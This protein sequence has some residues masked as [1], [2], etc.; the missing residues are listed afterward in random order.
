MKTH[1]QFV[2][3]RRLLRFL[4]LLCVFS[5]LFTPLNAVKPARAACT[6]GDIICDM[7]QA[8]QQLADQYVTP[9]KAW[10]QLQSYKALYGIEYNIAHV[11]AAF[12]WTISRVLTTASV[13]IGILNQWIAINFFQP[14]IQMT[15]ATM[16]PIVGVFLFAALCVLGISYLLAAFIRLNV[17]SLRSVIVWWI[18][19]GFFFSLGPSFYLSMRNLNQSLSSVFQASAVNVLNGQNPFQ[20]L[21][22]G[23]S[24]ANNPVYA[25]TALCSN[26]NAFLNSTSGT[27]NGLDIS[28]A[29]QKADGYDVIGGGAK[30][31]GGGDTQ[32]L[33]RRWFDDNGFFDA[34]KAPGSWPPMVTCPPDPATCD[35]D[36]LVQIEAGKMQNSVN[37]TFAGIMR[38]WQSV[39]LGWFAVVEQL[40]GLCLICAQGLT[41]VSFACAMVFAFFKRTEPIAWAIV[42]Q[43]LSLIVQS[44][45]IALVQGMTLALYLAAAK[46]GSPLV[47]MAVSLAAL[48]FMVIL[49]ISGLKAVW[50]SFNKL[51]EAFGQASGGVF[52]SPGQAGG[53]IAGT[54]LNLGSA[55]AT[56]GLSLAAGAATAVGS[57]AG[58]VQALGSGATWAQA[59]GVTFGGSKAL[60]GAAYH[61]ARLPG[62]RNTGIGEAAGQYIEGASTRQV[63]DSLLG[64]APVVGGALKRLG[65]ASMGAA[66]LTDHNPD[67]VEAHLDEQGQA[68]W[69]QPMLQRS[70][71]NAVGRLLSGPT[72]QPGTTSAPNGAPLRESDGTPVNREG[73]R[74][75]ADSPQS[76]GGRGVSFTPLAL[77]ND[78][79]LDETLDQDFK[80]DLSADRSERNGA[81]NSAEP[82]NRAG[83]RLDE[84]GGALKAGADALTRA[85][86]A[87]ST[88]KSMEQVEGRLNVSGA[89]NVAPVMARVVESLHQQNRATGQE[90]ANTERVSAAMAGVM[91]ISPVE[92]N[93]QVVPPIEGRVS[94][95][96]MFADQALRMGLSGDEAQQVVREVK[97]SPDGRLQPATRDRLAH[98]QHEERGEA[99][100]DSVQSVQMLEHSARLLPNTISAYGTRA[101]PTEQGHAPVILT[102]AASSG[103]VIFIPVP[104]PSTPPVILTSVPAS[105]PAPVI[106]TPVQQS[107]TSTDTS[108]ALSGVESTSQSSQSDAPG[109]DTED[110]P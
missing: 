80:R 53:M 37:L 31:L 78:G 21:A 36:G 73:V 100:A 91:G 3:A 22:G 107:H 90:G 89:N 74:A 5:G 77:N 26:F 76:G 69:R 92:H 10:V 62:L 63:G 84:A 48:V 20:Q 67:H 54:A 98:A 46:S 106:F 13:G 45:V 1:F 11:A 97:A 34:A 108:P 65:G 16:K 9:L 8:M 110:T 15:S 71:D 30:C 83:Q 105:P 103:S 33:P 101:V 66:L 41:F 25:M 50:S 56:G 4:V 29:F 96:Q 72:W 17:V 52:L 6:W 42:D 47:T 68:V 24:Q 60:D 12:M 93:G 95:Y 58:G 28:L 85:A 27:V 88:Q 51:F 55:A 109:S 99:W 43:W 82:L 61:V 32:D 18:A 79:N 39:P 38:E 87:N 81:D 64:A 23:D 40:V 59:A 35:Y 70:T 75:E 86:Q 19:G 2:T 49:V 14:M 7:Q 57:V 44:I 94:R 102:P 104:A